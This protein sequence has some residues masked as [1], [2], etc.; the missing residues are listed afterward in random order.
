MHGM[1]VVLDL[2]FTPV[3]EPAYRAI[4]A[5]EI[6][7][8]GAVRLNAAYETLDEFQLYVK[9]RFSKIPPH[10]TKITGISEETIRPAGDFAAALEQFTDW[11]GEMPCQFFTWSRSDQHVFQQEALLKGVTLSPLF[12]RHWVDLQRIHQRLYGF[13]KPMN[14][15]VALG[16]M[17]VYYEGTEHGALAD[18][19]NT[20]EILRLLQDVKA[21]LQGR[22]AAHITY[23]AQGESGFSLSDLFKSKK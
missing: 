9:P 8:V 23:N 10:V 2:E 1:K 3:K 6:I 13:K 5:S 16:S 19:R 18:A 4:A 17:H 22:H 20:A 15:T 11:I 12:Y 21:V 7:E 14:L